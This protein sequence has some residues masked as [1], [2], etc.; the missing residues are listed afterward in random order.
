MQLSISFSALLAGMLVALSASEVQA[1]PV[2]QAPKMVTLP[3]K[4]MGS[5]ASDL[6]PEIL[7]QQKINHASKRLALMSGREA[8][9]DAMMQ[10]ALRKRVLAI[11]G[12]EGV[13]RRFNR[14]Q[15]PP[16]SQQAKRFNRWKVPNQPTKRR[17]GGNK[18]AASLAAAGSAIGGPDSAVGVQVANTPTTANSLALNNETPDI[19]YLATVQ[20]GTPPQNFLILMDSGSADLWVASES[21]VSTTGGNCGK[22]LTL[23][24]TSSTS[25]AASNTPFQ[26]TYGTGAVQGL[27]VQDDV[28]IA[29]LTLKAHTFGATLQETVQFTDD[30]VP[31]DGL[32][33]LAQSTLSQQQTLTP[34]EAL[35]KQG[36]ITEAITSYKISRAADGLND[37]E[38]TFGGLDATKFNKAT[39][40]TVPNVNTQGFWEAAVDSFTVDGKDSGL[41]G[42]TAILDTGTTLIV[43]PVSDATA[44]HALIQ[45]SASTGNGGFTIPCN[46]NQTIALTVGKTSFAIDPR[47]MVVSQPNAQGVCSSGISGGSFGTSNTEWLVGDVFLKNAYY[48]TDVGKNTVSLAKLV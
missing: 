18:A 39:L 28:S 38:I 27:L 1:V 41:A 10:D 19:G 11:E 20:M 44:I 4:R 14:W 47:D 36:S 37:G 23:G 43:A 21:C 9:T 31:F 5:P 22:H 35:A 15:V 30:S 45:G 32:M 42:R 17:A 29:G 8:P 48:S 13:E 34:V 7:L 25:F 40:T 3:I 12:E 33:G 46:F 2:A 6:H 16:K 24:A 26:V